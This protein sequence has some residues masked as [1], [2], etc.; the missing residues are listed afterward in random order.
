MTVFD[1]RFAIYVL[2]TNDALS[3]RCVLLD[4]HVEGGAILP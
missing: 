3:E 4:A 1:G 2:G